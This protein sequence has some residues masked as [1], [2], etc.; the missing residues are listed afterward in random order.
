MDGPFNPDIMPVISKVHYDD[1]LGKWHVTVSRQ[2]KT[3]VHGSK[4]EIARQTFDTYDQAL[5]FISVFWGNA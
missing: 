2:I 3:T 5:T 1:I 4:R